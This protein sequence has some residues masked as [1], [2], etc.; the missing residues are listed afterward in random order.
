MVDKQF[1]KGKF[2]KSVRRANG[3]AIYINV[4]KKDEVYATDGA[5]IYRYSRRTYGVPRFYNEHWHKFVTYAKNGNGVTL[6]KLKVKAEE[7]CIY[8]ERLDELAVKKSGLVEMMKLLISDEDINQLP[9]R[10][11]W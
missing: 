10:S 11:R 7:N 2:K 4:R 3:I 1:V 6:Q 8:V 9:E 5:N